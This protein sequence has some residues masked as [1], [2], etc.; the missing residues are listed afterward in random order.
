MSFFSAGF[1]ELWNKFCRVPTF[2]ILIEMCV[3]YTD[4]HTLTDFLNSKFSDPLKKNCRSGWDTFIQ[5]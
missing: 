5:Y 2:E 1:S 4:G 3:G